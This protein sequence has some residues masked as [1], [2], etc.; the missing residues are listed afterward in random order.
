[1][2]PRRLRVP[3]RRRQN[4]RVL[5]CTPEI[6]DL[7]EGMGN[8]ANYIRAKGG[9]LGDIS[10]ALINYLF[11]DDRFELHVAMPKYDRK[12][13][14][15][16]RASQ[17]EVDMLIPRL[18]R[19]GVHLVTDSTFAELTDIYADSVVHPRI[20]R[21]E[22]LQRHVINQLLDELRPDVVHCNDWMTGLIPAAAK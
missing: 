19:K 7:P 10:A 3:K 14:G 13:R 12:I 2:A 20:R 21:A 6:T 18:Q 22:A 16:S 17:R 8:A 9:G 1:M 5:I 11:Q 15:F 4:A